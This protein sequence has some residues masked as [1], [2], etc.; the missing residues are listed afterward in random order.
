[1]NEQTIQFAIC[2]SQKSR[3]ISKHG[4]II[5]MGDKIYRGFNYSISDNKSCHAEGDVISKFLR[6]ANLLHIG[7]WILPQ[8]YKRLRTDIEHRSF[9]RKR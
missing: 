8:F 5:T 4:A 1:M 9:K 2:E 7:R 3:C 6:E